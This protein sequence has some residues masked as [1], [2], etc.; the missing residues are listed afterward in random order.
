MLLTNLSWKCLGN[1]YLGGI[2]EIVNMSHIISNFC[3]V[4]YQVKYISIPPLWGHNEID[5]PVTELARAGITEKKLEVVIIKLF[6]KQ[7]QNS[8]LEYFLEF[9]YS[10]SPQKK[11]K[12]EE[13]LIKEFSSV[14]KL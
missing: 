2:H 8:F 4:W 6:S 5:T 1:T 12:H 13:R 10:S 14:H 9:I 11:Q 7:F 3:Y